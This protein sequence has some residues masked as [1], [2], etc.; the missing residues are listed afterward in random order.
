MVLTGRAMVAAGVILVGAG[1]A[2]VGF[3]FNI[4][5]FTDAPAAEALILAS[6]AGD[7]LCDDPAWYDRM[8]AL[9]T[10]KWRFWDA[11]TALMGIG[12]LAGA[13]GARF[14]DSR[15]RA[16]TPATR[17]SYLLLGL[18]VLAVVFA[19]FAWS[20]VVDLDRG[21]FKICADSIGIPL[22]GMANIAAVI[23]PLALALGW[24]VTLA[25]GP[26]PTHLLAWDRTRLV[27]SIS[28]SVLFGALALAAIAA[29]M[30]SVSESSAPSA[31]ACLLAAYLFLSTR[32]A[33]LLRGY[34]DS[35]R[36]GTG[37]P[38]G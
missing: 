19:A 29:A 10:S 5:E 4:P 3:S 22:F 1:L 16:V 28:L 30:F 38:P 9:R 23:T 11:G 37:P 36:S 33:L 25:F 21:M 13:V 15:V 24:A 6:G 17:R 18:L 7:P 32:A 26:L 31:F 8:D 34:S 14:W 35:S 12:A 2:L 20:L 27:R